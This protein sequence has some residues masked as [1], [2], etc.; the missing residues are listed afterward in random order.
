MTPNES[1]LASI[2]TFVLGMVGLGLGIRLID[3]WEARQRTK[4]KQKP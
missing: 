4:T 3:K 1:F 2:A